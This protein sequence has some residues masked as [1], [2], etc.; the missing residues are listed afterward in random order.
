MHKSQEICRYTINKYIHNK[1][2]HTAVAAETST[3]TFPSGG[4]F[5][6]KEVPETNR[7]RE[8]TMRM[9]GTPNASG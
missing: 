1:Q 9:A 3:T 2:K 6:Y 5:L 4:T 7:I 8:T